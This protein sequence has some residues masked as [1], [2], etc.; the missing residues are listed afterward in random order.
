MALRK[1]GLLALKNKN[2]CTLLN[3]C[4]LLHLTTDDDK[5][6]KDE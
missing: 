3:T 5:G 2:F 6:E 4:R 1:L